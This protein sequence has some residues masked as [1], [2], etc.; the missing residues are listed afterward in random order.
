[1]QSPSGV[2]SVGV[3]LADLAD[4]YRAVLAS[5]HSDLTGRCAD[6]SPDDIDPGFLI[7]VLGF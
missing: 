5:I 3:I 7:V 6:R 4:D 1:L 2:E